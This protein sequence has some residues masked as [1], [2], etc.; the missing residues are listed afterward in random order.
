MMIVLILNI[1]KDS[2]RFVS[3]FTGNI[4]GASAKECGNYRDLNLEAAKAVAAKYFEVLENIT[5]EQLVYPE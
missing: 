5:P 3:L 1:V 4:P 2:F